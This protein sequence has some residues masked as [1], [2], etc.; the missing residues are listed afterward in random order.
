MTRGIPMRFAESGVYKGI[1][2]KN[3]FILMWHPFCVSMGE[4]GKQ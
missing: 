2:E 4:I 1:W 3:Q